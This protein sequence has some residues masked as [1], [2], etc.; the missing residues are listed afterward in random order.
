MTRAYVALGPDNQEKIIDFLQT[1]VLFPPDDTAS[2]LNPGV[3]SS[4][5]PQLPGNHGS[6]SLSPLFQI[7]SEGVE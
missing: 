1:L 7:P 2:N 5:D 6:I 3:P 4:D